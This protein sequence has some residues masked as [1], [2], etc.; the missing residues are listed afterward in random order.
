MSVDIEQP[1][2]EERDPQQ[3]LH[4]VYLGKTHIT[5][6]HILSQVR[7]SFVLLGFDPPQW[8]YCS[9]G[10]SIFF[11][12]FNGRVPPPIEQG[13]CPFIHCNATPTERA[14]S[15]TIISPHQTAST[16]REPNQ[17]THVLGRPASAPNWRARTLRGGLRTGTFLIWPGLLCATRAFCRAP[18]ASITVRRVLWAFTMALGTCR[19]R[20]MRFTSGTWW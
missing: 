19:C 10:I 17:T 11:I 18:S 15:H 16:R 4:L 13:A 9:H 2:R 12:F 7:F 8:F 3:T 14:G 1:W 5:S 6:Y 20:S